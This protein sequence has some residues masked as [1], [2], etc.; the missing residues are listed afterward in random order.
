M[1]NTTVSI[2]ERIDLKDAGVRRTADG[3]MVATPRVARAGIQVYRG[4]E[5]ER[6]QMDTVQVYRP[7]EEVFAADSVSSYGHRPVTNDH[8]PVRVDA[9]NWKKYAVGQTGGEVVRDG[10][11]IRVPMVVMD[12]DAIRDVQNGKRE[13]SLGYVSELVWQAGVTSDGHKYDAVQKGIRANHLA[14]VDVARGGS[15]LRLGDS[16]FRDETTN[17]GNERTD[18][19]SD[20]NKTI[21]LD[22]FQVTV[23]D[24]AASV[25]ARIVDGL[26]KR[27]TDANAKLVTDAATATATI[28]K[29]TDQA[30]ADKKAIENK[31]GEIAVLRKQVEDATLTPTKLDALVADRLSVVSKAK[32]VIGDTFVCD[33]KSDVEIRRAVVEAKLGAPA[34]KAMTDAAVEGAFAAVT[35]GTTVQTDGVR[36]LSDALGRPHNSMDA[37][38]TAYDARNKQL[39][40]AYKQQPKH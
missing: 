6:P 21:T 26:E 17:S 28:Q 1:K 10:D 33:G 19:M 31:D 27:V 2:T 32:A 14:I 30:T 4:S 13:L 11:T 36:L 25:I 38:A 35:A 37:A 9:K 34:T 29:M 16:V 39:E 23:P 22:G 40:N 18:S 8:P 12:Q 7:I 20:N 15:R 24:Q 3:Y 5:V